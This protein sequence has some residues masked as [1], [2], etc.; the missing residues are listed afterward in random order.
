M[1]GAFRFY[2]H[3]FRNKPDFGQVSWMTQACCALWR[4]KPDPRFA[5][6][7]FEIAEW[8]LPFQQGKSGAFLNDHQSDTPGYTS[9]LYLEGVAAAAW[10]AGTIGEKRRHRR[11]LE[12]CQRGLQFLDSLVIQSRDASLLPNPTMAIGGLR[13]SSRASEVCLDFVQHYVAA[14]IAILQATKAA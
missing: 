3:R 4:L 13:R 2:R 9:A 14:A 11:Y 1:L 6:L 5:E 12:S 7:A 10:L 8:I